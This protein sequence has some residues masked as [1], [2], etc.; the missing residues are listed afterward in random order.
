MNHSRN[1]VDPMTGVHT[2]GVE[3]MWSQTK[4]MMRKEGVMATTNKLF[5]SYLPIG[6]SMEEKI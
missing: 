3:S 4:R 6:I 5:D 2:Q 1:L